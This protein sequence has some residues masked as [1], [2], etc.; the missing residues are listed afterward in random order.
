VR[1]NKDASELAAYLQSSG[2]AVALEGKSNPCTDNL[3]GSAV[4]AALRTVAHP[5]DSLS[6]AIARGLP[7]ASAWGMEDLDSFRMQTLQSIAECGYAK[8]LQNWIELAGFNKSNERTSCGSPDAVANGLQGATT[9]ENSNADESFLQSRAEAVLAA[10]EKFDTANTRSEGIDAF[11]AAVE[12]AE[13][14]EA[15]ASEAIRIMTIHQAKG[16]GFEMVIVSGLDKTAHSRIAD[17]LVLGPD[18]KDPQW[19]MLLPRKDIAEAD[20]V[21]RQQTERLNAESKTNELSSAY[22]ALTRAKRALYVISDELTK[23]S[24]ATH[25][26]RH[27][28]LSLGEGWTQGDAKWFEKSQ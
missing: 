26:G 28:K 7:C 17:E 8:T 6:A 20:P 10:A 4:L 18:G 3:F 16:L 15:E 27:L 21:L 5:S 13:V 25:F 23:T 19:G 24:K 1:Q 14:Q 22:V 11:I 12:S 9:S 2:I